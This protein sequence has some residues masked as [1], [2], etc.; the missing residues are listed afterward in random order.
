MGSGGT[1]THTRT[2]IR[3]HTHPH[4]HT[5]CHTHTHTHSIT[6]TPSHTHTITH[7]PPNQQLH[8]QTPAW[9]VFISLKQA[10]VCVYV[11][12]C[13]CVCVCVVCMFVTNVIS[14]LFTLRDISFAGW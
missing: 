7:A 12:V 6:Q 13:V 4:T 10:N 8:A 3:S 14:L 1:H 9:C 5:L 11:C 2:H